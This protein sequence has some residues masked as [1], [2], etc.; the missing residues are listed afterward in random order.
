MII[1]LQSPKRGKPTRN[2]LAN[3]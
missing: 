1:K 2:L 3:Q